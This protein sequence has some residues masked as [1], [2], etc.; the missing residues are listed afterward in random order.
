MLLAEISFADVLW[1]TVVIFFMISYLMALFSIITDLFRD[2]ELGGVA[3]AIW[4]L[5]L[6]ILPLLSMLVYLIVRGNGMARRQAAQVQA[7]QQEFDSYVRSVAPAKSPAEQVADA[8]ALLDQ[9]VISAD[10]FEAL[11]RKALS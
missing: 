10:E 7:A 8:K 4:F 11:K 3:K 9:G 5:L 2:R 6:L 1:S